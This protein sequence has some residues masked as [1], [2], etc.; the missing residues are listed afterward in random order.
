MSLTLFKKLFQFADVQKKEGSVTIK[1]YSVY[2]SRNTD[3]KSAILRS[4]GQ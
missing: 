1:T 2:L 4:T 3:I